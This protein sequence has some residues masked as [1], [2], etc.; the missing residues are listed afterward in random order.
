MKTIVRSREG[1]LVSIELSLLSLCLRIRSPIWKM[2]TEDAP[3]HRDTWRF[4]LAEYQSL[5]FTVYK[6]VFKSLAYTGW[7]SY[8]VERSD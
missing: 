6:D 5:Y 8:S 2:S 3:N 7:Y 4:E 1:P